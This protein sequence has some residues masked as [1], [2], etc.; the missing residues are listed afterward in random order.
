MPR[1]SWHA[2]TALADP[3]K[4]AASVDDRK[5]AVLFGSEPKERFVGTKDVRATLL[6]W[7]LAFQVR[8]GV[9]AGLTSSKS[10]AW[11]AANVDARPSD[12]PA[13]KATPYRAT[14]VY[15]KIEG[16]WK[17]V[18]LQFSSVPAS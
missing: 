11:V 9:A 12:K 3:Q 6:R 18:V 8:D 5:D 13:A 10:V 16:T 1:A 17:L 2:R 15:E 4:L 7:K 14:L